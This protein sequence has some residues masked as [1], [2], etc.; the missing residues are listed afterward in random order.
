MYTYLHVFGL[1]VAIKD[2][3]VISLGL[4]VV[5]RIS[6]VLCFGDEGSPDEGVVVA[7]AAVAVGGRRFVAGGAAQQRESEECEQQHG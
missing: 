4:R 3:S 1:P 2:C 6:G 7:D 5:N